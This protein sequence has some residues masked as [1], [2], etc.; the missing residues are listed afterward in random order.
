VVTLSPRI[1]DRLLR[2]LPRLDDGKQP[3]AETARRIGRLADELGVTRPSYSRIRDH[4]LIE[5]ELRAFRRRRRE[6]ILTDVVTGRYH[7]ELSY[8]TELR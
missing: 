6:R 3:I 5:R 1:D 2:A 4:V 8:Y 7:R